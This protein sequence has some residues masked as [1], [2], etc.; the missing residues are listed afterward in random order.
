MYFE[1]EA[2]LQSLP[3]AVL[4]EF[5]PPRWRLWEC[6][7]RRARFLG[8]MRSTG[9]LK[10]SYCRGTSLFWYTNIITHTSIELNHLAPRVWHIRIHT[11]SQWIPSSCSSA[12]SISSSSNQTF[13]PGHR[14]HY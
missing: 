3:S 7:T 9:T 10:G 8:V 2:L 11:V 6:P 12:A 13:L 14:S 5:L 1:S 4:C